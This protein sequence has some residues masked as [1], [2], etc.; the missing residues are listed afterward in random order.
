MVTKQAGFVSRAQARRS[1]SYR[2]VLP[3]VLRAGPVLRR[4][5]QH[6]Q[7]N[8]EQHRSAHSARLRP[9]AQSAE[10]LERD[11]VNPGV[12]GAIESFELGSACKRLAEA[13]GLASES[14]ATKKLY[15]IDETNTDNFRQAMSPGSP[16][17]GRRRPLRRGVIRG[18]DHHRD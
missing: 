17:R 14:A 3:V 2:F 9:D 13:D 16:A 7:S 4:R 10:A 15:G 5:Q 18:W 11:K 12:E 6:R 8:Q 1:V